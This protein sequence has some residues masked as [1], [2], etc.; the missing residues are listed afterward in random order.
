VGE[1]ALNAVRPLA[2]EYFD[3]AVVIII[4]VQLIVQLCCVKI[5]V[6]RSEEVA[7]HGFGLQWGHI[8]VDGH[9]KSGLEVYSMFVK[10]LSS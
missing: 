8:V 3:K 7:E 10:K 9:M 5:T 6:L 4:R 1:F 2:W